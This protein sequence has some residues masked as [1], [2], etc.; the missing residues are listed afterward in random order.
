MFQSKR[1]AIDQQISNNDII[2]ESTNL[3]QT[4]QCVCVC[5]SYCEYLRFRLELMI[6]II[7]KIHYNGQIQEFI[8]KHYSR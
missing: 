7:T 6:Q 3:N 5:G 8:D 4:K 2:S 1:N